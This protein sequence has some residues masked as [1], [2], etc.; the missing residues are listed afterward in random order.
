MELFFVK[1][2]CIVA[3]ASNFYVIYCEKID[4]N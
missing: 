1:E 3:Y 4:K 2:H